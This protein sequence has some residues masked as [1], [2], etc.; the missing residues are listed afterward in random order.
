M[1]HVSN[2]PLIQRKDFVMT[3]QIVVFKPRKR[4][5]ESNSGKSLIRN[6]VAI[7]MRGKSAGLLGASHMEDIVFSHKK[8]DFPEH[9]HV[10]FAGFHD[11]NLERWSSK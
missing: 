5:H 3:G 1:I 4:L 9:R 7:Y 6:L 8:H 2:E 10:F 11:G